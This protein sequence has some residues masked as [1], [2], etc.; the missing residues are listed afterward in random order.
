MHIK[1]D[2][3]ML[4]KFQR[5]ADWFQDWFGFD[6]FYI[7]KCT[8]NLI[9]FFLILKI[10]SAALDGIG[11]IEIG[12]IIVSTL[13]FLW[14]NTYMQYGEYLTK[15]NTTFRNQLAFQLS[16]ERTV[17]LTVTPIL[18]GHFLFHLYLYKN[19]LLYLAKLTSSE[20]HHLYLMFW[21]P[22]EILMCAWIYFGS[23]TPKSCTTSK[24]KRLRDKII[25]HRKNSD[26]NDLSFFIYKVQV[27]IKNYLSQPLNLRRLKAASFPASDFDFPSPH[28][29][30]LSPTETSTMKTFS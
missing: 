12:G 23:C 29:F 15:S 2:S 21:S 7:A 18:I 20:N 6:N 3:R 25:K 11:I 8:K 22:P 19:P 16:I 27:N 24:F 26:H 17:F 13:L 10:I 5:I 4:D 14:F 30:K 9:L 28:I 1:A